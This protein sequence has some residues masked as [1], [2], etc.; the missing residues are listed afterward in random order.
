MQLLDAELTAGILTIAYRENHAAARARR[1]IGNDAPQGV[2]HM[3]RVSAGVA[4]LCSFYGL[5]CGTLQS[6]GIGGCKR[7][8]GNEAAI[9]RVDRDVVMRAQRA[10]GG[11]A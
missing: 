6:V 3:N 11:L 2:A 1:K 9:Q 5:I 4:M 7:K 10:W 8:Y